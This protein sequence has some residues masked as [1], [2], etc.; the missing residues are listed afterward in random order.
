MDR[1]AKEAGAQNIITGDPVES[2]LWRPGESQASELRGTVGISEGEGRST[3]GMMGCVS[4]WLLCCHLSSTPSPPFRE[5]VE[6]QH[7][8]Y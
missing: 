3:E 2:P 8:H 4:L 6:G 5:H 1:A 7:C